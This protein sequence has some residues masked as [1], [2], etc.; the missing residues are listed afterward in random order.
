MSLVE[1]EGFDERWTVHRNRWR[2]NLALSIRHHV[3]KT[4]WFDFVV[5]LCTIGVGV[6][7]V[8]L[9]MLLYVNLYT[10]LSHL[11]IHVYLMCLGV[12]FG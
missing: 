1:A 2:N 8:S 5:T 11:Y 7:T 9:M 12:V 4:F 10:L 3:T 6:I